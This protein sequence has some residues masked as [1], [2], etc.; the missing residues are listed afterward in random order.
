MKILHPI[1]FILYIH[2]HPFMKYN[3][4]FFIQHL[5]KLYQ[6]SIK[7]FIYPHFMITIH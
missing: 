1:I 3:I 7:F 4:V 5:F 2:I 6:I